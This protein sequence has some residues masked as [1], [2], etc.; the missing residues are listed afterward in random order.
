[1]MPRGPLFISLRENK[2]L[3]SIASAVLAGGLVFG[4]QLGREAMMVTEQV[5]ET[6]C[7]RVG[8]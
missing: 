7:Q 3:Q 8:D 1:M 5:V 4:V 6:G 2:R